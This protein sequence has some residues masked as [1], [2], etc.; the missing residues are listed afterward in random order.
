MVYDELNDPND[1]LSEPFQ[2]RML[3]RGKQLEA[4]RAVVPTNS[5]AAA[6][7]QALATEQLQAYEQLLRASL[8]FPPG[9]AD[10]PA[11]VFRRAMA[12]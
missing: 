9:N 2:D 7:F 12:C 5:D 3:E 8:R 10:S 11:E 1:P 4:L 6:E